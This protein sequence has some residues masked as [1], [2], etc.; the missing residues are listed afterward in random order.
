MINN[1]PLLVGRRHMDFRRRM[2][3]SVIVVPA[4]MLVG[5]IVVGRRT[6]MRGRYS[7]RIRFGVSV[8]FCMSGWLIV[9]DALFKRCRFFMRAARL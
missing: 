5:M 4:G 7:V 8:C 1:A 6:A 3:D 2:L 9:R